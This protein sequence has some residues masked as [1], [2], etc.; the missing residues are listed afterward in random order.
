MRTF[1][2]APPAWNEE[3][4]VG[5]DVMAEKPLEDVGSPWAVH[6][7]CADECNCVDC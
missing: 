7:L 2:S 5:V 3:L 1:V 6:R 4:A